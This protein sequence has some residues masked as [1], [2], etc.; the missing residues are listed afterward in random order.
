MDGRVAVKY[1]NRVYQDVQFEQFTQ[2]LITRA[3]D[4]SFRLFHASL[5]SGKNDLSDSVSYTSA[6]GSKLR[7]SAEENT[8]LPLN[9]VGKSAN[10]KRL[11]ITSLDKCAFRQYVQK[12]PNIDF[13]IKL[14]NLTGNVTALCVFMSQQQ[15]ISTA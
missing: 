8:V 4:F 13:R 5:H 7:T 1:T 9:S 2:L 3:Q 15:T 12:T 11:T 6:C 14:K 10:I